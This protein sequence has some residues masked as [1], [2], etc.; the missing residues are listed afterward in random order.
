MKTALRSAAVS[1]IVLAVPIAAAF[2]QSASHRSVAGL[3]AYYG[4]LPAA[5]IEGHPAGHPEQEMHGG[6]PAGAH[7]YHLLVAVFDAQSGERIENAI[8]EARVTPLGLATVTRSLEPMTIAG[9]VTYGNYFEFSGDGRYEITL[10]VRRLE[11]FDPVDIEFIYE[12]RTR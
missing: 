9:T 8:V 1:L 2:A 10:S 12:H 7:A 3:A 5:M 11:T 6:V 4:V